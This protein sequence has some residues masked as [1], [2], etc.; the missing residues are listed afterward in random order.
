MPDWK[1]LAK[2]A[3]VGM[4]EAGRAVG[5]GLQNIAAE[6]SR[7]THIC[8]QCGFAGKPKM[9]SQQN[10]C[11]VLI[12]LC[13][14]VIP[15]IIYIIA[16]SKARPVCPKCG[17]KNTMIPLDTPQAQVL[18][19]RVNA[20][21]LPTQPRRRERPCPFYAE[22]ILAEARVCKHCGRDVPQLP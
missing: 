4:V 6:A 16:T 11:I 18:I 2:D 7:P 13:F 1:K 3:G 12:L 21:A 20:A 5:A 10:G 15:G 17:G 19:H 9:E 14:F 8:S 22:P